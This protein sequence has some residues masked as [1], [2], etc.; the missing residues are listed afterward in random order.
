MAELEVDP[1]QLKARGATFRETG[2]E[3]SQAA[4]F[5]ATGVEND[6]AAFGE[7]NA[8]LHGSWREVKERQSSSWQGLGRQNNEHGD[9]LTTA[10]NG[11]EG[12][13]TVNAQDLGAVDL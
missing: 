11:Y 7:I 12:T 1:S 6:I 9:K 4:S 2:T 8:A 5:D 10:A 13:D 3:Q